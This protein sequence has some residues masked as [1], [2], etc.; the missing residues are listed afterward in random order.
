MTADLEQLKREAEQEMRRDAPELYPRKRPRTDPEAA[1]HEDTRPKVGRFEYDAPTALEQGTQGFVITCDFRREMSATREA[2]SQAPGRQRS[3]SHVIRQ[4]LHNIA[5][6]K[7]R[8]LMHFQ[9]ILP[10]EATCVLTAPALTAVVAALKFPFQLPKDAPISFAV[11]YKARLAAGAPAATEQPSAGSHAAADAGPPVGSGC[12]PERT[13]V[14]AALAAGFEQAM[15]AEGRTPK[16][17][18]KAPQVGVLAEA[19]PIAGRS[20]C[21][22]CILPA[23]MIAVKPRLTVKGLTKPRDK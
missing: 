21:A 22:I 7:Q 11:G 12:A 2:I 5:E 20:F 13:A 16:V 8:P 23:D 15:A 4:L 19:L 17:D 6:Q 1:A 14:I 10:V 18:L 3:P 9:R